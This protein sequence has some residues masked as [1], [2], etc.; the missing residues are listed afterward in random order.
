MPQTFQALLV[1]PDATGAWTYLAVPFDV[2]QAYGTKAR[3]AVK[4][5]VNG[6][7]FRSSLLPQGD[8]IHILVVPKPLRTAAKAAPGDTV[9]V[10]VEADTAPRTW[11]PPWRSTRRPA[12]GS[13]PCPIRT[14]K[15]TWTGSSRPSA[16]R[17]G[18][19]V[20]RRR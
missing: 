14:G 2:A 8:G 9:E 19:A 20:S 6:V 17:P 5:T 15:S 4:G 1:H 7:A 16:R 3:V 18:R 10:V 12:H 13:R 11:P